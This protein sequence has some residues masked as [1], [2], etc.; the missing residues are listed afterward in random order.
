MVK[1]ELSNFLNSG[2]YLCDESV[3]WGDGTLP[4]QIRYYLSNNQ[5]P[6]KYVSSARAIV[7]SDES[8]LVISDKTGGKYILP[9]GRIEK[10]EIPLETLK[11][12]VL[13]ETGYTLCEI[14]MLGF[15]HFHHL[16]TKPEN[17]KYPYPDFIWPIYYAEVNDFV[18][19]AIQ[20]DDYVLESH[21]QPIREVK[22]LPIIE[23]Q[24]LL[25]EEAI[26]QRKSP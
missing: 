5:P 25:L 15:M 1:E 21:F 9:G 6:L 14:N 10:D 19:D 24:L 26:E 20:L 2:K 13:E 16:G 11:R 23:G 7:F 4:I 12:E 22:N 18:A 17:Y 3:T 8:I